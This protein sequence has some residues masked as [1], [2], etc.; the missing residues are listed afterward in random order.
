[1]NQLRADLAVAAANYDS[2]HHA[3]A[4]ATALAVRTIETEWEERE[5]TSRL[6]EAVAV[7][8][9]RAAVS[10]RNREVRR[11]LVALVL[12]ALG[13]TNAV[14]QRVSEVMRTLRAFE[15]TPTSSLGIAI[16]TTGG[17]DQLARNKKREKLAARAR[18]NARKY[19]NASPKQKLRIKR[20]ARPPK[21]W[22]V[23]GS[24]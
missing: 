24:E 1:M 8:A 11:P 23:R 14:N 4:T 16:A 7:L 6:G 21:G 22:T 10:T 15:E 3:L 17:V 20:K 13:Q 19:D 2:R 9:W 5:A 18:S 12:S